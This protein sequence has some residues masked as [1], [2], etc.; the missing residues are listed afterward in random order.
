MLGYD[1]PAQAME[2]ITDIA[3]YIYVEP[4][5]RDETISRALAAGEVISAEHL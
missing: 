4:Q 3:N 2:A 1:N 5:V